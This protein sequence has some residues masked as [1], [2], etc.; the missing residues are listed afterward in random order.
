MT[1]TENGAESSSSSLS[2]YIPPSPAFLP[3][4]NLEWPTSA[5]DDDDDDED[6]DDDDDAV[7][8]DVAASCTVEVPVLTVDLDESTAS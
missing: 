5:K 3:N 8:T 7:G 6:A 1:R 2:S 4:G